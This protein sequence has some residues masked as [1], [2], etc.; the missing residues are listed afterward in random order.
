MSEQAESELL[1]VATVV[2]KPD[3]ADELRRLLRTAVAAFRQEDGCLGYL[4]YEDRRRPGRF[5]T[6]ETWRDQGALDAHMTSPTMTAAGPQ[7]PALLAEPVA[8]MP[9]DSVEV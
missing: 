1:V 4:L 3:R 6:Y 9:L 7:L 5:V 8:I 2:A